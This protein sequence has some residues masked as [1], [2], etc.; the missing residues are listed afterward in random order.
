MSQNMK[1]TL[2]GG[3]ALAFPS[4]LWAETHTG[5]CNS[6]DCGPCLGSQP[7]SL[8]ILTGQRVTLSSSEGIFW[9]PVHVCSPPACLQTFRGLFLSSLHLRSL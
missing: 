3:W 6:L 5:A 1:H 4:C 9:T 8:F 2:D 7:L